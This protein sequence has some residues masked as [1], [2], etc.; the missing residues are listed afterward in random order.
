MRNSLKKA[1]FP[2]NVES[3]KY[4]Q[5]GEKEFSGKSFRNNFVSEDNLRFRKKAPKTEG[6]EKVQGG[7]SVNKRFA[8]GLSSRHPKLQ[9]VLRFAIR[10]I[11]VFPIS[12]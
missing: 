4:P 6:G 7:G 1:F 11:F 9:N 2:G 3:I 5:N 12:L 10:E 8:A